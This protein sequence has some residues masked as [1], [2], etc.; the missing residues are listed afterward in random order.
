MTSYV[1]RIPNLKTDYISCTKMLFFAEKI[2]E[3]EIHEI[4]KINK[5]FSDF[6]EMTPKEVTIICKQF[7]HA[8][9]IYWEDQSTEIE[10][11]FGEMIS[12][13]SYE[14]LLVDTEKIEQFVAY[15][16]RHNVLQSKP[17]VSRNELSIISKLITTSLSNKQIVSILNSFGNLNSEIIW[18][19]EKKY[20]LTDIL[21]RYSYARKIS[22]PLLAVIAGFFNPLYYLNDSIKKEKL[23]QS[24]N[25]IL[26]ANLSKPN[27][28]IWVKEISKYLKTEIRDTDMRLS[29]QISFADKIISRKKRTKILKSLFR[30]KERINMIQSVINSNEKGILGKTLKGRSKSPRQDA[31]KEIKAVNNKLRK[32]LELATDFIINSGK[33]YQINYE[34]F[35][36]I[37]NDL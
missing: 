5:V 30:G 34:K 13:I 9:L 8:G 35:K 19:K 25:Q 6:F 2:L 14:A 29:I 27:T 3:D 17:L 26:I 24:V 36:I 10:N 12:E 23:F 1:H 37:E 7:E 33:G 22:P 11:E 18:F 15:V 32:D 21:F 16:K 28:K 31:S 20:T 4:P